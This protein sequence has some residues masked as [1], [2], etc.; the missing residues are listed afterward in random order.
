MLLLVVVLLVLSQPTAAAS[1]IM[2]QTMSDVLME[3]FLY[4]VENILDPLC[5]CCAIPFYQCMR[6]VV[7]VITHVRDLC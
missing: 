1:S 4:D 5:Q 3:P 6:A 2:D 7:R